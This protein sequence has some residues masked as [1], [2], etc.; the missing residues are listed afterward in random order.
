MN[1]AFGGVDVPLR[2]CL[3][4]VVLRDAGIA[5]GGPQ[6]TV[7][8]TPEVL[9]LMGV[10]IS[11]NTSGFGRTVRLRKKNAEP[12]SRLRR[13]K[14][15]RQRAVVE[16]SASRVSRRSWFVFQ[17]GQISGCA[18]GRRLCAASYNRPE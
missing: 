17:R 12:S 7:R 3:T 6:R 1:K 15:T 16:G 11:S 9:E 8:P 13:C 14:E 10:S 4:V 18:I 5:N 2:F